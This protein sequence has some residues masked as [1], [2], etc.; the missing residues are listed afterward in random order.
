MTRRAPARRP[1]RR[2]RVGWLVI[3]VAGALLATAG[4]ARVPTSGPVEQGQGVKAGVDEPF[5]RVLPQ[6]PTPGM[7][8]IDLTRGFLSA[9]AS[10]DGDHAVARDYLTPEAA[11]VWRADRGVVVYDDQSLAWVT[12]PDHVVQ[13]RAR[14]LATIDRDGS[15][16]PR[17]GMSLVQNF[18]LQKVGGEWRI[19]NPPR[20]LL[21]TEPD[22]AR[23][24]RPLD[25]FFVAP[26]GPFLVPDPV[27]VPVVRPGA[28][29]SLVRALLDGPTPWLAPAVRTAVPPETSLVVDSV[30]VENG[31]AQVNLTSEV[32]QSSQA[33]LST[34]TAQLVW[35]LTQLPEV[36]GVQLSADGVPLTVGSTSVQTQADWSEYDP[37]SA[38]ASAQPLGVSAGR[39]VIIADS[40][41]PLTG[42]FGDGSY[43]LRTPAL[44]WAGD[45][46]AAVGS[47]GRSV[48]VEP[49]ADPGRTSVVYQGADVATPSYDGSGALW[50][51]DQRA[52]G[53]HVLVLQPPATS[54]G[55]Q[56]PVREVVTP[57]LGGSRIL[58]L[59]VA[60]DGTRAALV[61]STRGGPGR[62]VLARIVR[63]GDRVELDGF[64]PVERTLTQ[65]SSVA[66]AS[67]DDIAV[68]GQV[69]SAA[70]QPWLVGV[71]GTLV[72]SGGSLR[73]AV[74][75]AAAPTLPLIAATGDGRA[76]EDTG[77]SWQEIAKVSDPAYAG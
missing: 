3:A 67:A 10:F 29:T 22:V 50:L 9:S 12:L 77:L 63:V 43:E 1:P 32:L 49:L 46:V 23:S 62:L 47:D 51:V 20:R 34:L 28:A 69:R 8:P 44:S 61:V 2:R 19:T 21:L 71:N 7:A 11:D 37:N 64:R 18:Q 57:R 36:T 66:W 45:R 41:I 13:M 26:S 17:R 27:Y 5:I 33:D 58:Q 54:G 76:W 6:V 52:D 15:L 25:L 35:T 42:P 48:L 72:A 53:S 70:I 75:I 55:R 68:L 30:P 14:I 65:V 40:T 60:R 73:G 74:S 56:P 24:F 39:V 16:R 38:P 59:R 31:V 4:C